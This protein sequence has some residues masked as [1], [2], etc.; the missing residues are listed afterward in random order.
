M[1]GVQRTGP[2]DGSERH[3]ASS[4]ATSTS[5]QTAQASPPP[6]Q[7]SPFVCP[8]G[9]ILTRIGPCGQGRKPRL[10]CGDALET[11]IGIEPTTYS[12][13]CGSPGGTS[14]SGCDCHVGVAG[15]V[16]LVQFLVEVERP[17]L[18]EVA[19]A[20]QGTE[21]QDGFCAVESPA[22]ARQVEP[23]FD[24][25]SACAF[26]DPGRDRPALFAGLRVVEVVPLGEQVVGAAVGATSGA[27]IEAEGGGLAPDRGGDGAGL[28]VQDR[29]GFLGDPLLGGGVAFGEERPGRGP[30]VLQHVDEVADDGDLY[31]AG[32]G[33][34]LDAVDLVLGAVDEG[35]PG[36]LV[37]GVAALCFFEDR[38]DDR[39]RALDHARG[40]PLVARLGCR[41]PER[42]VVVP[43]DV[44]GGPGQWCQVVD[45][46]D[47]GHSFP[48][49][50][51]ALGQSGRQLGGGLACC[52]GG[53]GPQ[54]VG[55]HHDALAVRG[56][57]QQVALGDRGLV[58]RRLGVEGLEVGCGAGRELLELALAE[59]YARD[60]P[61][62]VAAVLGAAP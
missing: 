39:R 62:R 25:V 17:V 36:A 8:Q 13:G 16:H 18:L 35:D 1:R 14:G 22:C 59:P 60:P 6:L 44:G 26:D 54:P 28:T 21:F 4:S 20:A 33:L 32:S 31:A 3:S 30:E 55:S 45:G 23:V 29:E 34:S 50:L 12:L 56:K 47:L 52:L 10:N 58:A 43:D 38:T 46:A 9:P 11:P 53:G 41:P 48:V 19:V 61:D 5:S 40:E 57:D 24:Q 7:W 27:G 37:G 15:F 42:V 49:A 51:L 2:P